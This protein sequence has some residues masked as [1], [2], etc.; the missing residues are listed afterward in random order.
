MA[1]ALQTKDRKVYEYGAAAAEFVSLDAEDRSKVEEAVSPQE[2]T[3]VR[4][5]TE[6]SGRN[7]VGISLFAL[8]GI[9]AVLISVLIMLSKQI[10]LTGISDEAVGLESRIDELKQEKSRLHILYEST[11]D[12][13]SVENYAKNVLGMVKADGDQSSYIRSAKDDQVQALEKN[14]TDGGFGAE[15]KN[16]WN[17]IRS[18]F[19]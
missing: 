13:E 14:G 7:R 8:I 12:M 6:K 1:D 3:P 9:P 2:R 11:F 18:I 16:I 10:E 19:R 4:T 5:K 17:S 15:L